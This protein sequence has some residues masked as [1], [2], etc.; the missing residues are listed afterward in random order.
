MDKNITLTK[1][2]IILM[3]LIPCCYP[4][5]FLSVYFQQYDASVVPLCE[6]LKDTVERVLPYWHDVIVPTIKVMSYD[7]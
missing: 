4:C 5:L 7:V 1:S 3:V 2:N 6:C